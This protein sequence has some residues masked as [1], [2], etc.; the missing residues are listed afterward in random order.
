MAKYQENL[1]PRA[2]GEWEV[3][4]ECVRWN[5]KLGEG[6]FGQVWQG[7]IISRKKSRTVAIKI[8]RGTNFLFHFF[9]QLTT[10]FVVMCMW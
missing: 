3:P 9:Q 10:L 4:Y 6:Q 5:K 8:L 7:E 2:K 1:K